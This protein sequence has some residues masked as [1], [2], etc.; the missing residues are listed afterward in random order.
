MSTPS[1][2]SDASAEPTADT[3][4]G[5]QGHAAAGRARR[6][7]RGL[8]AA[9]AGLAIILL[10]AWLILQWGILPRLD[11]W[12]PWLVQWA[13][14]AVGL[15]VKIDRI[16]VQGD[17]WAPVLRVEGLRL[18]GAD[19]REALRLGR[20]EAVITPGSLLPRSLHGWQPRLDRLEL[21]ALTL[22]LRRDAGGRILL[23]GR[24]LEGGD[25]KA[26]DG[27]GQAL[28]DWLASQPHVALHDARLRWIDA[29]R[30]DAGALELSDVDITLDNPGRRHVARLQATPPE[31]WGRRFSVEADLASPRLA[32]ARGISPGDWQRWSGQLRA[33][34]PQVDVSRLRRHVDLPFDLLA[35][36]GR[37][38]SRIDVRDGQLV[39]AGLDLQLET[40]ALRL[41]RTLPPLALGRIA[42]QLALAHDDER[43]SR[44]TARALS[45]E[46]PAEDGQPQARWPATDLTLALQGPP[47]QWHGGTFEAS[48]LDLALLARSARAVPLG[49]PMRRLLAE[50]RPLGEVIGLHYEWSGEAEL[51][52]HW[53]ARGRTEGLSLSAEPA[54]E[55][56]ERSATPG[57]PGLHGAQV[58]FDA[59]ERGGRAGVR[60]GEDGALEF[61]GVFDEPRVPVRRL[62]AD[63][64]WSLRRSAPA[65]RPAIEV[66]VRQARFATAD[67]Q[68]QFTGRW[69]S[70]PP[71][72]ERFGRGGWLPG[73]LDLDARVETL[74]ADR[75]HRYLPLG[76]GA[77]VRHYLAGALRSGHARAVRSQ[78]RG[79]VL[80]FPYT[81]RDEPG[82]F[83][84][85]GRFDGVAFDSVPGS[86]WPAFTDASGQLRI[87]GNR[88]TLGEIEAR[89]GR[90]GSGRFALHE[91]EG[92]IADFLHDPVLRLSGR[93]HGP[94]GDV[95]RYLVDSP[96]DGWLGDLFAPVQ[97]AGDARLALQL[98]I[99]VLDAARTTLK[100]RVELQDARLRMRPDTPEL[101]Q[102]HGSLAFSERDFAVD[103]ARAQVAG[104]PLQFAGRLGEDG[105]MRL[106][107]QGR[108][109][110]AGL[111][112]LDEPAVLRTLLQPFDGQ[113]DY[114][115]ELGL[116]RLGTRLAIDSELVG[117]ASRLP[118][119][120]DKPA[121]Q[122][123]ALRVRLEPGDSGTGAGTERLRV[124]TGPAAQPLLRVA[125][126]REAESGRVLRGRLALGSP[127][128]ADGDPD[129][130]A[131]GVDAVLA[132]PA[133]SLDRWQQW[134]DQEAPADWRALSAPPTAAAAAVPPP[135]PASPVAAS[136]LPTRLRLRT[137]ALTLGG[138]QLDRVDAALQR[139]VTR[140]DRWQLR[141]TADQIDGEADYTEAAPGR[142][143][144]LRARL[145]RLM[146][147]PRAAGEPLPATLTRAGT[148][149]ADTGAAVQRLPQLD[150]QAEAVEFAGKPLGRLEMKAG[151]RPGGGW[152]IGR[153]AL[154]RPEAR[155]EAVGLWLPAEAAAGDPAGQT[156]MT[157]RLDLDDGGALLDALGWPGQMQGGRG[158]LGGQIQWPGTPTDYAT[159]RLGGHLRLD[160]D[161][162][163][164]PQ[165][166]PG[167]GRLL[168]VLSLQSLPRRFLLDFRD[169]FQRGFGFDHIDGDVSIRQGLA[170]TRNLRIRGL[171]A[172]ILTEGSTSL[173]QETQNLHVWVVPD[174]NAGA[175]SLAYA[176]IN[177]AVG[178]GTLLT[179][180]VLKGPLA[181]VATREFRITGRWDTPDVTSVDR[182]TGAR[183]RPDQ[184]A[185][186]EPAQ[187]KRSTP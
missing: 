25:P 128:P 105:Q 85:E 89:L 96:V 34:W 56:L 42:G 171:Q 185:E 93:G 139:D 154:I 183:P 184:G 181:D 14:R 38:A 13:S 109:S 98:E 160:L 15:D 159:A 45:F 140:A 142:P 21:S 114:R 1:R 49:G 32:A 95:V 29:M 24:P 120:L 116:G 35:G 53:R 78:V 54:T 136:H 3:D 168:G 23:A 107:G 74:R 33:D 158:H 149:D 162:G 83:L 75:V 4:V 123:M 111:R 147:M 144:A 155:L 61:P 175:A 80:D 141:L 143:A 62:Q 43:G 77:P 57:R 97:A 47:G 55:Q 129:G 67:G 165:A 145:A 6:L 9:L 73:H 103:E 27:G 46:L 151:P 156:R 26:D 101:T 161:Q 146:L 92:G 5:A 122:P 91:V 48:R 68:G 121:A 18:S 84:I 137:A 70:G 88:L 59:T 66:E 30:P 90:T 152:Q 102:L 118:A 86:R 71:E 180:M 113:A 40:V 11:A 131:R 135:S 134:F 52:E 130:P 94:A 81:G 60:M 69:K 119:P 16:A 20:A 65:A 167:A 58:D 79:D 104:G 148:V 125:Y 173:A 182:S 50:T 64:R 106:S 82:R 99:P 163:R 170:S 2:S 22:E 17:L 110:A 126:L 31:G 63:V 133:L 100:G 76:I 176:V 187:E 179:Q 178:L 138:R 157:F 87:D 19:G 8:G 51:P 112:A 7:L 166:D 164:F 124:E 28:V 39:Q 174:L 169:L 72:G 37:L 12:R 36:R 153:L 177:P 108:A 117:L 41:A 150:I 44:I 115:I 10:A 186:P 127:T 172:M 132:L